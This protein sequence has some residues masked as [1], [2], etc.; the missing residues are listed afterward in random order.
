M[1]SLNAYDMCERIHHSAVDVVRAEP[2]YSV[3]RW[4]PSLTH[5]SLGWLSVHF[6]HVL[7]QHVNMLYT[8]SHTYRQSGLFSALIMSVCSL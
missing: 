7:W 5:M 2:A 3:R 1:R 6:E 8:E 4:A